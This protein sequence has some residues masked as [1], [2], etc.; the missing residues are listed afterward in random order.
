MVFMATCDKVFRKSDKMAKNQFSKRVS[1]EN[2]KYFQIELK[3]K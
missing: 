3:F 2:P 1:L